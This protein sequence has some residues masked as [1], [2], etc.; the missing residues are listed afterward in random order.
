MGRGERTEI[1][2][3][4]NAFGL[5]LPD[6]LSGLLGTST[7]LGITSIDPD[8]FFA[9]SYR[10]SVAEEVAFQYRAVGGDEQALSD[11]MAGTF[12]GTYSPPPNVGS[13][14]DAVVVSQGASDTGR[15]RTTRCSS[16]PCGTWTT[17]SSPGS[18]T[19]ARCCRRGTS[20][21]PASGGRSG[22]A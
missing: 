3:Q 20:P 8:N 9:P 10:G 1:E 7:A 17:P 2:R 15:W 21:T 6:S 16:R 14:G 18:S 12:E 11:L 4:F 13:E 5:P 22:S 19:C